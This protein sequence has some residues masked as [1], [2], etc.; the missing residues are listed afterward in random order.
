[1]PTFTVV[2]AAKKKDLPDKGHGPLQVIALNMEDEQG[3]PVMAEWCTKATT[4]VPQAG[5]K[6][7]GLIQ[8]GQFGNTFKKQQATISRGGGKSP[9]EQAAIQ[10]MHAQKVGV[11]AAELALTAGLVEP[12]KDT[13]GLLD[14]IRKCADYFSTDV[15]QT[16][17]KAS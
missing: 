1:M 14:F 4:T 16:K 3:Q 11:A 6:L 8:P 12:P 13:K 2:N 5:V 10:R 17:K 7:E 9:Q 15:D